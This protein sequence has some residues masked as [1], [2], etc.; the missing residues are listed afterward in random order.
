M[1]SSHQQYDSSIKSDWSLRQLDKATQEQGYI[2]ANEPETVV[3]QDRCGP[4]I[5]DVDNPAL[6]D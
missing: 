1:P 4:V 2:L 3:S 6:G 5:I